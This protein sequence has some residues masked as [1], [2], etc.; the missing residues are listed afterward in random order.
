MQDIFT[1]E[2]VAEKLSVSTK[3]VKD[4]LR[5][6]KLQGVKV[7][8]LWRVKESDLETFLKETQTMG[9]GKALSTAR[10]QEVLTGVFEVRDS[11]FWPLF[12]QFLSVLLHGT[13]EQ[14]QELRDGNLKIS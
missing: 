12:R 2:Q 7:G 13:S 5:A 11:A 4:W 14:I 9:K 8:R 10:V 3:T 6:G 1:P